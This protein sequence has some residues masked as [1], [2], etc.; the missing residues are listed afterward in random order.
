MERLKSFRGI[1]DCGSTNESDV[2]FAKL[3]QSIKMV[4]SGNIPQ[5]RAENLTALK[6]MNLAFLCPS[7]EV[8]SW[9][10]VVKFFPNS[11]HIGILLG[12]R[13]WAGRVLHLF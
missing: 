9:D 13:A 1:L 3:A 4:F 6:A 10:K 12:R 2:G 5:T 7:L 11:R 8:E